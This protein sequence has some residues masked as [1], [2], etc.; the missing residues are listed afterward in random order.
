MVTGYQLRAP[1]P[2][3]VEL[4]KMVS[5]KEEEKAGIRVFINLKAGTIS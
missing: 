4:K 3:T 5:R 2:K 1:L